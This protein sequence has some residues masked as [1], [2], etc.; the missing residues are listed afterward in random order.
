MLLFLKLASFSTQINASKLHH[1]VLLDIYIS[2]IGTL[3]YQ[4]TLGENLKL[5]LLSLSLSF[6]CHGKNSGFDKIKVNM[7]PGVKV[8]EIA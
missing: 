7:Y 2:F 8:R 1:K 3:N 6:R 5:S 4:S